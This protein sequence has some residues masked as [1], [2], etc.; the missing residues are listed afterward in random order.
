[1][2]IEDFGKSLLADVRERKDQ[3]RRDAR[4]YAR[5]QQNRDLLKALVLPSVFSGFQD[6]VGIGNQRVI[7]KTNEFL[8]Q[9]N[10]YNNQ[11]SVKKAGDVLTELTGY[12][13]F[14]KE[15]G[16]SFEDAVSYMN[17]KNILNQQKIL[18]PNKYKDGLDEEYI[19]SYLQSPEFKKQMA[20]NS[21]Y[22]NKIKEYRD[23][24]ERGTTNTPLLNIA[25]TA[26]PKTMLGSF[27]K[28]LIGGVTTVDAFNERMNNLD[29]VIASKFINE[30]EKNRRKALAENIVKQTGN[31]KLANGTLGVD[32]SKKE[33]ET[34]KTNIDLGDKVEDQTPKYQVVNKE[35]RAFIPTLTTKQDGNKTY[36]LREIKIENYKKSDNKPDAEQL[37]KIAGIPK[38]VAD[39]VVAVLNPEGQN[40]FFNYMAEE[41]EKKGNEN[42]DS[43]FYLKMQSDLFKKEL[44]ADKDGRTGG[45]YTSGLTDQSVRDITDLLSGTTENLL[46]SYKTEK[47]RDIGIFF[48]KD[49]KV[50]DKEGFEKHINTLTRLDAEVKAST[51]QVLNFIRTQKLDGE[52]EGGGSLEENAILKAIQ[53]VKNANKGMSDADAMEYVLGRIKKGELVYRNGMIVA[54]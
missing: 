4:S 50:T 52:T 30:E 28:K 16:I 36:T 49:G 17:A 18:D 41:A 54:Q 42:L 1:M 7:D 2:A 27:V 5:K 25:S 31:V 20:E 35:L 22:Y 43:E 12:E 29:Q 51:Q 10:L 45:D 39:L 37:T 26:K 53:K 9:S 46:N 23:E 11:L 44:W 34:L 19:A 47:A 32:L 40:Q 8:K 38:T 48:G 14:A 15:R 21:K 33:Q 3:Q 6:L 13:N 24:Y